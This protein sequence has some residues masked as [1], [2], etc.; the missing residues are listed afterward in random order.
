MNY[1]VKPVANGSTR[2]CNCNCSVNYGT[3][4]SSNAGSCYTYTVCPTPS[5]QKVSPY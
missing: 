4:C 3:Y 1:L 5:G 2:A